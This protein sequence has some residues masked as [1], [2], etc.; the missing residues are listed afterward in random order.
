MKTI[1]LIVFSGLLVFTS[2]TRSFAQDGKKTK[3]EIVKI[4][5]SM[6]CQACADNIETT[7]NF[8]KGVKSVNADP[9][10]K[11]VIIEYNPKKTSPEKLV[12][13]IQEIG[14]NASLLI[15]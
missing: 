3:S 2:V 12:A 10:S 13:K 4:S 14:Y 9:V 11:I 8:E 6:H 1:I 15:E 7:L 5:A